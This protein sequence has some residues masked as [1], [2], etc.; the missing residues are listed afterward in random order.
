MNFAS[1]IVLVNRHEASLVNPGTPMRTD[2]VKKMLWRV[3]F[4]VMGI[5]P[6]QLGGMGMKR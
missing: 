4:G 5:L 3:S 2:S 6:A 1:C